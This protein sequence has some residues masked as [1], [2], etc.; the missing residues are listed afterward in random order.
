MYLIFIVFLPF[1]NINRKFIFILFSLFLLYGNILY[2]NSKL[3][4]PKY[5][6]GNHQNPEIDKLYRHLLGRS[7]YFI[8]EYPE[9]TMYNILIYPENN[10]KIELKMYTDSEFLIKSLNNGKKL[11]FGV[12]LVI[13]N[14]DISLIDYNTDIVICYFDLNDT[15][16]NDYVFDIKEN[17][18][19]IN[20]NGKIS[21]N[22]L[23]PLDFASIEL[24]LL[25]ENVMDYKNYYCVELIKNSPMN[26]DNKTMLNYF[27]YSAMLM[28]RSI[29]GFYGIIDSVEE[30]KEITIDKMLY[31]QEVECIDGIGLLNN[32]FSFYKYSFYNFISLLILIFIF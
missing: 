11:F 16:C 4:P 13:N 8:T 3:I 30:L 25:H 17:S 18:Y 22:N 7:F 21:N 19:K 2:S 20:L 32:S 14:T 5:N 26:F 1:L 6:Y 23:I 24:N 15:G 12:D 9:K 29:I 27:F 31:F 10:L 28:Q